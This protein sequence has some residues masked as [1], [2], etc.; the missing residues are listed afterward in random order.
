MNILVTGGAGF[1]GSHFVEKCLALGHEVAVLDD[2]NDFY[3]PA[4]KRA[5]IAGF[6]KNVPVH[7]IDIRDG[8]AV[9]RVVKDGRFETIVHLAARAGVRP[10]IKDPEAL[11]RHQHHRHLA[12]ARGGKAGRRARVS[13]A[14]RAR[15]FMAC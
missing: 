10:S 6:I 11:P 5:N 1:I 7:E 13:S 3:D 8:A 9:L 2:F 14:L 12:S 15:A 4:I